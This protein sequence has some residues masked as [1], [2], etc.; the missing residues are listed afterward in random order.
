MTFD[1]DSL[2][3]RR[4]LKRQLSSWRIFAIL[5]FAIVGFL[6]ASKTKL[7]S[8]PQQHIARVSIEGFI[9][10]DRK[11]RQ[12]LKKVEESEEVKGVII[13]INSPGGTTAGAEGLYNAI[14]KVS[15]KKPTVAVFGTAATSAAYL[16]AIS[17]D[18]IVARGNSITGSVGVIFQWAEVSNLLKTLGVHVEEVR[19]GPLKAVPSPFTA[20]DAE[21][22]KLW[23]QLVDESKDWFVKIVKERRKLSD[24]A[25]SEVQTGRVYTGRQALPV[26]LI[27]EIG[28]EE[29][30]RHWLE[31]KQ[32]V[33]K[34]LKIIDWKVKE[35]SNWFSLVG[36][37]NTTGDFLGAAVSRA[38]ERLAK[39]YQVNTLD[40][41]ISVWHPQVQQ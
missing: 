35:E 16:A 14:R 36:A 6:I 39:K 21:A 11:Q 32:N 37:A 33:P 1:A 41:L 18:H 31:K 4:R 26:G 23:K 19:S 28:D 5:A 9:S 20:T 25:L 17:T 15:K 7:F 13:Y 2:A 10:D 34:D 24:S 40:G 38:G 30:A 8:F 27:D 22:R 29:T 3:D 12:L